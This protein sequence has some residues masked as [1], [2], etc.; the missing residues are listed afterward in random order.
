MY[1]KFRWRDGDEQKIAK[2][3]PFWTIRSSLT[4]PNISLL[5]Q[6]EGEMRDSSFLILKKSYSSH[7][8]P[9]NWAIKLKFSMYISDLVAVVNLHLEISTF[10]ARCAFA[11]LIVQKCGFWAGFLLFWVCSSHKLPPNGAWKLKLDMYTDLTCALFEGQ[12]LF[13]FI[14]PFSQFLKLWFFDRFSA[15]LEFVLA[16]T[17]LQ[18]DI[19][20][21]NL[22][23]GSYTYLLGFSI[24]QPHC[25][26]LTTPEKFFASFSYFLS[27]FPPPHRQIGQGNWNLI[28]DLSQVLG[29][30]YGGVYFLVPLNTLLPLTPPYYWSG[31]K[32]IAPDSNNYYIIRLNFFRSYC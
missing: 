25:T 17:P 28:V 23:C 20:I 12:N 24:F 9:P 15:F 30:Y 10:Q 18:I 29:V 7:I 19:K 16:I 13:S 27:F 3:V 1:P 6:L 32:N 21:W 4:Y 2:I 5:G 8:A 14:E 31:K 26:I 11:P 22:V